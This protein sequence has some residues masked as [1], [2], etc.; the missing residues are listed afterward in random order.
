[1]HSTMRLW[2]SVA[3]TRQRW[4]GVIPEFTKLNCVFVFDECFLLNLRSKPTSF[5]NNPTLTI[6][7]LMSLS[8]ERFNRRRRDMLV[9]SSCSEGTFLASSSTMF[10]FA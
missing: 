4:V 10:V 5:G 7:L 9:R 2:F 3:E 1:M 8:K 6:L